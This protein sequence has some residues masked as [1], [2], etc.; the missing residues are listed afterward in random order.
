M[1]T[2]TLKGGA[3]KGDSLVIKGLLSQSEAMQRGDCG[4]TAVDVGKRYV[5]TLWEPV[6]GSTKL[7]LVEPGSSAVAY[8]AAAQAAVEGAIL[9]QH[10]R[11]AWQAT[12]SSVQTRLVLYPYAQTGEVDLFV[13]ARNVGKAAVDFTYKS[14]PE[15][16]QS[17]CSLRILDAAKRTIDAKDVPIS[18]QDIAAYF[19]KFGRTYKLKIEPGESWMIHLPRVTTAAAGWGYK[20]ELG[21]KYYPVATHGPHTVAAECVN[22]F[23]P[24]SQ[25][26]TSVLT[27]NL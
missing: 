26:A 6:P 17:R 22:F 24:G 25:L 4:A 15:A 16:Q 3:K 12:A 23:G 10:P 13:L 5:V 11:S 14:W 7:D 8:T 1:V 20:E 19:S 21:F 27:V 2:A 18:K 9:K